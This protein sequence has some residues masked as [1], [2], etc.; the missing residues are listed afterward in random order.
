MTDEKTPVYLDDELWRRAQARAARRGQ[1]ADDLVEE[2]VRRYL[3]LDE[4][5]EQVWARTPDD[6]SEDESL[7]LANRELHAMRRA[8]AND[9]PR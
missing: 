4:F 8:R 1:A 6:L 7:T 9:A 2:A 5:L 3:E